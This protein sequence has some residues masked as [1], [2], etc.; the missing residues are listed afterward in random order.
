MCWSFK[1]KGGSDD[2]VL[3]RRWIKLDRSTMPEEKSDR[4]TLVMGGS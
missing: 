1:V 2:L 3:A 4:N